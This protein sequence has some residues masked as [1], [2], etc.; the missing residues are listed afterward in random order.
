MGMGFP[1]GSARRACSY[2]AE[3][4]VEPTNEPLV[5]QPGDPDP[6]RFH[7]ER[8]YAANSWVAA[9]IVWPQ[10]SNYDGRK[11]CVFAC[12]LAELAAATRLDPHFQEQRG[13]LV[14]LARFEPTKRGWAWACEMVARGQR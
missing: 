10:A 13:P 11:V 4:A 14:P 6:Y 3:P 9:I 2:A 7:I 8:T 5:L 1:F 12:T